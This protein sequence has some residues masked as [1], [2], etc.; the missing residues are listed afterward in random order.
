M[1]LDNVLDQLHTVKI[2]VPLGVP[3]W[4][5]GVTVP[6]RSYSSRHVVCVAAPGAG[7]HRR[8]G[9]AGEFTEVSLAT[10]ARRG[11]G[12]RSVCCEDSR[13][14]LVDLSASQ[15]T[16]LA[17]WGHLATALTLDRY[18]AA[19]DPE[20]TVR[21]ASIFDALDAAANVCGDRDDERVRWVASLLAVNAE[22][23]LA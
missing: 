22:S 11:N 4:A 8:C 2:C 9:P 1:R 6:G 3:T 15:R 12:G 21:V 17:V 5:E 23:R 14:A 19:D 16:D 7:S 18:L 10:L 13:G 20:V